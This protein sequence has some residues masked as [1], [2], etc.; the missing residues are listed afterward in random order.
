[1]EEKNKLQMDHAAE[2]QKLTNQI[3]DLLRDQKD[4]QI[5]KQK[6]KI[7]DIVKQ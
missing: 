3:K 2:T 7:D 4:Y 1:M 6:S 5:L